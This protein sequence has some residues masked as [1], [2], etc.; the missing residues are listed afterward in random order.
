M[1]ELKNKRLTLQFLTKGGALSSIKDTEGTE[2]LWQGDPEYWSGQAPLLF[3]ICGSIRNDKAVLA[4][5]RILSM[6]RHGI[7]RKKEFE[8]QTG[9]AAT[10]T[11]VVASDEETK[12]QYPFEFSLK[13]SYIL[14]ENRIEVVYEIENRDTCEIP[15]T[16][17]GHPGFNCPL[18]PGESFS[19]YEVRFDQEETCTVPGQLTETGLLDTQ[20]RQPML[21]HV[22]SMKLDFAQFEKDAI[23]FDQ[24][25]SRKVTLC[26]AETGRGVELLFDQF[27]YLVLWTTANHGPFLAMEPWAGLSTCTDEGDQFEE[28]RNTMK[29]KP[30]EK[31]QLSYQIVILDQKSIR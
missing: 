5:G 10:A 20:N 8:Y 25:Q 23:T 31:K 18:F 1:Y 19:D 26:H 30:G 13:V 16:I 15:F 2:Y 9:D 24:L 28:K 14:K 3:P 12:K 22:S 21:D 11:F 6:P 17:G 7:V 4:D 27:P 29:L